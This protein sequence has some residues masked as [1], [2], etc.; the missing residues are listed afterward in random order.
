MLTKNNVKEESI[1]RR[2]V[3]H[4][5]RLPG[6]FTPS[7]TGADIRLL[8]GLFT[9]EEAELATH[10][11]LDK[12]TAEIIG[13]RANI[14][15]EIAEKRLEKMAEKGL[16]FSYQ[17]RPGTIL[18]Q[19]AP[20]VIGIYE[21]QVNRLSSEFLKNFDEY[22][23]SRIKRTR[24]ETIPQLRT[25][26]VNQSIDSKLDVLPYEQVEELVRAH[27]QFAV[28][29]C[30]CRRHAKMNGGGCDALEESCLIFGEFAEFYVR[31]G[32]AR[33]IEQSEVWTILKKANEDNL[34]L[35][36]TNSKLVSAICCCCG[37]CCGILN[38]IKQHPKPSEAVSSSFIASFDQDAC[39]NCGVCL[40]RCQMDALS[41]GN[42]SVLLDSNRC[43]GCG[44]CASTCPTNALTLKRKPKDSIKEIPATMNDTWYTIVKK[45]TNT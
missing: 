15:T 25:I 29:P 35:N 13:N 28:A 7:E 37:D 14:P 27:D 24:P 33:S 8:K 45:Q 21:F 17:P 44:L 38:G 32:R 5:D 11:T 26:P 42:G 22:Y 30:I 41:A 16:I 4:L 19:A 10:L 40:E 31:T 23:S 43:I 36:P 6:G 3:E 20:W 9:M 2:L 1:Y 39:V 12:Q 34:V 18:Y